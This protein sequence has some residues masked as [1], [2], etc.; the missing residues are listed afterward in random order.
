M[1][2]SV[3]HMISDDAPR[4]RGLPSH[5]REWLLAIVGWVAAKVLG[6]Q[7]ACHR[8][9]IKYSAIVRRDG[10]GSKGHVGRRRRYTRLERSVARHSARPAFGRGRG[11]RPGVL[12][13]LLLLSSQAGA[14]RL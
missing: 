11:R 2:A 1:L 10:C 3:S 4:R 9:P 13:L 7:T 6:A 14:V 5:S 8:A 12:L